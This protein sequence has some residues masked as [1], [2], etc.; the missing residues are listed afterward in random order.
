MKKFLT[1]KVGTLTAFFVCFANISPAETTSSPAI[2][3]P[4][5]LVSTDE[6]RVADFEGATACADITLLDNEEMMAKVPAFRQIAA[7]IRGL[8]TPEQAL[9]LM[10]SGSCDIALIPE[11][12]ANA[13]LDGQANPSNY[14]ILVIRE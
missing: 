7:D 3:F 4:N 12:S 14:K 5:G 1:P 6:P 9:S 10:S 11:I 13:F 8:E 2:V